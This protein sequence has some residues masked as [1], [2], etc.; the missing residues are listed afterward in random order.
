MN[1]E[2]IDELKLEVTVLTSS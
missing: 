2:G 1:N